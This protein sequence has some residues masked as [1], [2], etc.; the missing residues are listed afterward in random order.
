[1]CVCVCIHTTVPTGPGRYL[2]PTGAR[3]FHC[4]KTS[5]VA[6]DF[7]VSQ[8]L[9]ETVLVWDLQL[10]TTYLRTFLDTNRYFNWMCLYLNLL[11]ICL[12]LIPLLHFVH[13]FVLSLCYICLKACFPSFFFLHWFWNRIFYFFSLVVKF[14]IF[15]CVLDKASISTFF[16]NR[17]LECFNSNH[18]FQFNCYYNLAFSYYISLALKIK[19]FCLI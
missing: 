19:Q 1:M 11:W 4:S 9:W 12:K 17:I 14:K 8:L 10:D 16:L 7:C 3:Y 18:S 15:I 6:F 13:L 5:M 2:S